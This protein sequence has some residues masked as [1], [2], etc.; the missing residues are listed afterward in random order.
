MFVNQGTG[1]VYGGHDYPD[2]GT[3]NG[4]VCVSDSIDQTCE[5]LTVTV[6]NADPAVTLPSGRST[7]SSVRP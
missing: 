6:D 7:R 4:E 1:Q 3:Y 2:N 5:P